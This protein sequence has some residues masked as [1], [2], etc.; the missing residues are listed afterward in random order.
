MTAAEIA[1]KLTPAQ[2]RALRDPWGCTDQDAFDLDAF[3]IDMDVFLLCTDYAAQNAMF[4]TDL[5]FAVLAA[6]DAKP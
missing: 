1:A 6:L 3:E 4:P 5:G 2:V